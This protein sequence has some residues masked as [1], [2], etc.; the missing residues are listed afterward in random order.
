MLSAVRR[1]EDGLGL[2]IRFYNVS[3]EPTTASITSSL[4][5]QAARRLNL[6]EEAGTALTVRDQHRVEFPVRGAEVVTCEL[7]PLRG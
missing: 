1:A 2:V 5:L 3:R 6:N 4:P 7:S